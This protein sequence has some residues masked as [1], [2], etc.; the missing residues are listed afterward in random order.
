[1]VPRIAGKIAIV[2]FCLWH[3]AAVGAYAAPGYLPEPF[4]SAR[5]QFVDFSRSYLLTTSQ[6]QKWNLF[7]PNPL[8]RVVS[9]HIDRE[10]KQGWEEIAVIGPDT[11]AWWHRSTE[12]KTIRRMEESEG[13]SNLTPLRERYILEYCKDFSDGTKLRLRRLYYVIPMHVTPPGIGEWHAFQP[14]WTQDYDVLVTCPS[15]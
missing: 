7:S 3:M 14:E 1:M 15:T 2:L 13:A 11:V 8:R 4:K 10:T 6:W 12:L 9:F 5:Q